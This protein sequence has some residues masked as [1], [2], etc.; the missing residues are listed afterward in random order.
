M[1]VTKT[2]KVPE[3]SEVFPIGIAVDHLGDDTGNC[4]LIGDNPQ[5]IPQILL[6]FPD[7]P[8]IV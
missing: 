2:S 8:R 3:R 7:D 5:E 1:P 4:G 6:G